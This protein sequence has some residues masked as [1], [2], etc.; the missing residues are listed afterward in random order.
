MAG[1]FYKIFALT[2]DLTK[3]N[4]RN[5]CMFASIILMLYILLVFIILALI[6]PEKVPPDQIEIISDL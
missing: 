6:P 2:V 3:E 4:V 1:I 5:R